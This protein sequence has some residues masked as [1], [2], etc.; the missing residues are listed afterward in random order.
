M[1]VDYTLNKA[2]RVGDHVLFAREGENCSP[3]TK[4]PASDPAWHNLGN[5][6]KVD[7]TTNSTQAEAKTVNKAGLIVPFAVETTTISREWK[8]TANS[9][10]RENFEIAFGCKVDPDTGLGTIDTVLDPKGWFMFMGKRNGE[11]VVV[12]NI[13]GAMSLD[14]D[15]SFDAEKF[16]EISYKL[17]QL[18][19]AF[20]TENPVNEIQFTPEN[21]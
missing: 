2:I 7:V 20:I 1:A 11:D 17:T 18:D 19:T 9:I 6:M 12:A 21:I 16:M 13:W 8:F 14:G 15:I 4:P 3:T 5:V 10:T